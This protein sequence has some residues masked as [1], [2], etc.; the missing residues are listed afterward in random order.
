MHVLPSSTARR[1]FTLI[2]LLI[3]IAIIAILAAMLLPVLES[4]QERAQRASCVNNLRQDAVA[5]SIYAA[6]N[7]DY[8]PPLKYRDANWADYVYQMFKLNTAGVAPPPFA[9][10]GGPYNLGILWYNNLIGAA[11]T[12][13][14][15]SRTAPSD[16]HAYA[17]YAQSKAWPIGNN[18]PN[19]ANPTWIRAGY[20]YLPSSKTSPLTTVD[21]F[22]RQPVPTWPSYTTSPQPYQTWICVPLFKQTA[23][24]LSKSTI[25]D[26]VSGGVS[27]LNH[28][29]RNS[30]AGLNA[31]FGDGHVRWQNIRSNPGIFTSSDAATLWGQ[32]AANG[33]NAGPDFRYLMTLFQP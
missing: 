12:A 29:N 8:M 19:D 16:N 2:E 5:D 21:G 6:D 22:G 23:V 17:Y 11:Q 14:C 7:S 24:D 20:S 3:V 9:S 31:A 13:Y 25:V 26:L 27:A 32:M 4:A 30:P 15:P 18:N 10:D 1:G 28:K 33:A